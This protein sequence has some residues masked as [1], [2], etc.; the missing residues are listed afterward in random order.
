LTE[1]L[2]KCSDTDCKCFFF[3]QSDL[4]KHLAKFGEKHAQALKEVHQIADNH[5]ASM[6]FS[7]ADKLQ[8]ELGE[9]VLEHYG[10]AKR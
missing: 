1:Q 3:T 9:I 7:G 6:E 8:R 10:A 4:A 2:F 5:Y